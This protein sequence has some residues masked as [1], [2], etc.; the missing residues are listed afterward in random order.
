MGLYPKTKD[1]CDKRQCPLHGYNRFTPISDLSELDLLFLLLEKGGRDPGD[2]L[3]RAQQQGPEVLHE[4]SCVL[5]VQETGQV[6][7]HHL[8]IWVLQHTWRTER[9]SRVVGRGE[10]NTTTG[11]DSARQ[12]KKKDE[13]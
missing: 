8:T 11:N 5:P 1:T 2:V 3:L 7:L 9:E 4:L 12:K 6:N 10:L 13:L